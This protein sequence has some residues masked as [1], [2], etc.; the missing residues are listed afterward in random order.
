MNRS[1]AA[2][3]TLAASAAA[4]I[5]MV[6]TPVAAAQPTCGPDQ[7]DAIRLAFAQLPFEPLTGAPWDSTPVDSNYDPCSELSTILV[8]TEGGTGSSPVQALL[9]HRG[10][11]VGTG[12]SK[13]Y[14]FTS[15]DSAA[16]SDDMV[17]LNYKV[18]GECNA[19][20]PAAIH[21]ARYRWNGDRAVMLDPP[22]P[23]A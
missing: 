3:M 8:T 21:S 2:M 23:T 9:F 20:A 13:A 1:M 12:T 11:Y 6:A 18:P 19:C 16:S 10:E 14:G 22:P 15:L 17:V 4:C 7:D 5:P